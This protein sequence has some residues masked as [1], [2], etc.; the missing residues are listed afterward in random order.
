M[1]AKPRQKKRAAARISGQNKS[2]VAAAIGGENAA[3]N[4]TGPVAFLLSLKPAAL[5]NLGADT[6][7]N[8]T[9]GL[10]I[11]MACQG[12]NALAISTILAVA[13]HE[14]PHEVGD[15]AVLVQ[16][17]GF[18]KKAAFMAQW[19][20]ALGAFAGCFA[21]LQFGK[22][23]PVFVHGFT[24]GGFIYISLVNIM[25]DML[26]QGTGVREALKQMMMMG[27]GVAM[28]AYVALYCE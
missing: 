13:V 16:Q 28:M 24:A 9:D 15:F 1:A 8:F 27:L 11:A 10:A 19:V 12:G 5:L 25:P 17:G 26:D 21:G 7:H 22:E 14:L 23:A 2:R 20:S 18:S 4:A 6:L 3:P